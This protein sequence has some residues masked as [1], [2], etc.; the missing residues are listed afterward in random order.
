MNKV[1]IIFFLIIAGVILFSKD[2]R[3]ELRRAYPRRYLNGMAR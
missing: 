2:E 1:M 3:E